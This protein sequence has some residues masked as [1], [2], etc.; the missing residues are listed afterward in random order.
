MYDFDLVYV[1]NVRLNV[2]GY[3]LNAQRVLVGSLTMNIT[4][5]WNYLNLSWRLILIFG[6]FNILFAILVPVISHLLFP[7][8]FLFL[9]EDQQ[10]TGVSWSDIVLLNQRLGLWIL[11]LMDSGRGM[12]M[13]FGVLIVYLAFKAVRTGEKW[14]LNAV[15]M[16]GLLNGF[17]SWTIT[18]VYFREGLYNGISGVSLGIWTS[19]LLY[20]P[21]MLGLAFGR[22]GMKDKQEFGWPRETVK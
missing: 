19:V 15:F 20:V 22:I 8:P 6:C 3:A 2:L 10:F 18:S 12:M 5:R 16:S 17:Y 1:L 21:W 13:G 4:A 11:L 7:K 9:S 14:A